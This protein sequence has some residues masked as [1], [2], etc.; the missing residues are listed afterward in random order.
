MLEKPDTSEVLT[1]NSSAKPRG[2]LDSAALARRRALFKGLGK[3][4]GVLAAAVPLQSMATGTKTVCGRQGSYVV[5]STSGANSA[6]NSVSPSTPIACGQHPSKYCGAPPCAWPCSDNVKCNTIFKDCSIRKAGNT[7]MTLM[8]VLGNTS[9]SGSVNYGAAGSRAKLRSWIAAW[10]NSQKSTNKY[11]YTASQVLGLYA[12]PAKRASA[13]YLFQ[14][15]LEQ[16]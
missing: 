2:E 12:D 14:N 15:Y 10:L 5:C 16:G 3:G 6:A 7:Q 1:S 4:A 9:T 11:P 13:L 8:E